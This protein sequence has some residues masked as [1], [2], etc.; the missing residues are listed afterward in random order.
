MSSHYVPFPVGPS[1]RFKQN[2][3]AVRR[4]VARPIVVMPLRGLGAPYCYINA[5]GARVC[6]D[7]TDAAFM[8]QAG[9][10]G[11]PAPP[12]T[13]GAPGGGL[14]APP[15]IVGSPTP[16]APPTIADGT[17]VQATP[18]TAPAGSASEAVYLIQ[19][20][21]RSW[22]PDEATLAAWGFSSAQIQ[23]IP[24]AQLLQIPL[25]AT[26]SS[27]TS[28]AAPAAP[29]A[30]TTPATAS[31]PGTV[32]SYM[33]AGAVYNAAGYYTNPDG[34]IYYPPVGSTPATINTAAA[35]T[36]NSVLEPGATYNATTG[37]Y[38]NPD[39]SIYYPA[40]AT[41]TA[42]D[43]T[44]PSTWPTWVWLALAAGI[45]LLTFMKRR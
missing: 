16:T 17:L 41:A 19:N 9:A 28:A 29:A 43:W 31:T 4:R 25:G 3:G 35:G 1:A 22:I 6:G 20:G 12:G 8:A 7:T 26:L 5:S 21:A 23:Q 15:I 39:G 45:G 36:I 11:Y 38:T 13:P 44:S 10:A 33:E 24:Y 27:V 2:L 40:T 37:Y 32:V 18:G 34:T 14:P 30:T 42:I